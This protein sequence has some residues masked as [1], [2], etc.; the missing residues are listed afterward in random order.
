[1]KDAEQLIIGKI[2][3]DIDSLEGATP[4]IYVG[5]SERENIMM[6]PIFKENYYGVADGLCEFAQ[7][8]DSTWYEPTESE[9]KAIIRRKRK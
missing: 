6:R 5:V 1:M 3:A 4:F 9:I 7:E 2:Y 8:K